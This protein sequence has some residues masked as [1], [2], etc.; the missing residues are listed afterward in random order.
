V[1]VTWLGWCHPL[2]SSVQAGEFDLG[3]NGIWL[4]RHW[5]HEGPT[6]E[7]IAELVA[8]LRARGIRRIYPFLG[9]TDPKG[10]SGWRSKSGLIPYDPERAGAFLRE[11]SSIAPEI[12]VLP[13]TGG[14]L[15]MD[16]RLQDKDQRRGLWSML[17]SWSPSVPMASISRGAL[18]ELVARF[19]GI[20]PGTEGRHSRPDTVD[21]CLSAAD[22]A[23]SIPR[24]PLGAA[25]SARRL[26]GCLLMAG[27]ANAKNFWTRADSVDPEFPAGLVGSYELIG[28]D[29]ITGTAYSGTLAIAVGETSYALTRTGSHVVVRGEAWIEHC[30]ADSIVVLAARYATKPELTDLRCA[31]G[32]DGD[33]YFRVTCQ[34]QL[35]NSDRYGLEA[36]FQ[37]R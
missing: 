30:D 11:I 34:T 3:D 13:W 25:V 28:K 37:Q 20:A 10:W 19:S 1:V 33:N 16:V 32:M 31:L 6:K 29:L 27:P 4:R 22:A 18:A 35:D 8:N 5:M 14:N 7:E 36:W 21:C 15:N 24:C 23:A 26:R 9:P 2:A 17:A 12:S